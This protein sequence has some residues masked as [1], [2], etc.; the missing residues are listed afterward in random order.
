[1]NNLG[2]FNH[3][4]PPK[5]IAKLYWFVTY[6]TRGIKTLHHSWRNI[7]NAFSAKPRLRQTI[8][9]LRPECWRPAPSQLGR[10]TDRIPADLQSCHTDV[11]KGNIHEYTETEW[12]HLRPFQTKIPGILWIHTIQAGRGEKLPSRPGLRGVEA[13]GWAMEV[14]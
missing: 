9:P 5:N 8:W 2:D 13:S 14:H 3:R 6:P 1:M 11:F 12:L 4:N 10:R 7:K